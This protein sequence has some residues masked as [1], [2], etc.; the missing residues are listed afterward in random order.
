[1]ITTTFLLYQNYPAKSLMSKHFTKRKNFFP[2]RAPEA[3]STSRP[4]G[5]SNI[6][7]RAGNNHRSA[8][9]EAWASGSKVSASTKNKKEHK[10]R[11]NLS[12]QETKTI[13][14]DSSNPGSNVNI[15]AHMSPIQVRQMDSKE[16]DW[17]ASSG[18]R[19]YCKS[20]HY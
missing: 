13:R 8:Q 7:L 10:K 2:L 6:I 14:N 17:A 3:A 5:R 16:S 20:T 1:M 9:G 12:A 15:S 18:K 4:C 11:S 19:V